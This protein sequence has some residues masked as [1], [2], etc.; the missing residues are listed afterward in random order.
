MKIAF[1]ETFTIHLKHPATG[2]L[3]FKPKKSKDGLVDDITKPVQ[4]IAYGKHTS[5]FKNAE[6]DAMK[7]ALLAKAD[8]PD[9]EQDGIAELIKAKSKSIMV[10]CIERFENI[11]CVDVSTDPDGTDYLSNDDKEKCIEQH[12]IFEQIESELIKLENF[13][14]KPSNS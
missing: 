11:D 14:V 6:A 9:M 13:T 10:A 4:V 12:W 8:N 5:V 2:K 1:N 3:L 7:S